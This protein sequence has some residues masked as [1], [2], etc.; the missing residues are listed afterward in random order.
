MITYFVRTTIEKSSVGDPNDF[1]GFGSCFSDQFGFG[2]GS[3]SE[4]VRIR[5]RVKIE[6]EK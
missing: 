5:I 4:C 3:G 6:H 1:F 2:F